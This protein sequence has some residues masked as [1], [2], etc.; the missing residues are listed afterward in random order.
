LCFSS[1]VQR[2]RREGLAA[3]HASDA[4]QKRHSG[5]APSAQK[6]HLSVVAATQKRH[7]NDV[8][9]DK[10]AKEETR[11]ALVL[12]FIVIMFLVCN[13]PRFAA[14]I[15]T[16]FWV[17]NPLCLSSSLAIHLFWLFFSCPPP[18]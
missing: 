6:R 13:T 1:A 17:S 12:F 10:H 16:V 3:R 18:C 8:A 2:S 7:A 9:A 15:M 14:Q 11:R 4:P 5:D